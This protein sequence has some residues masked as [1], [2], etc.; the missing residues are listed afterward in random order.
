MKLGICDDETNGAINGCFKSEK[1]KDS[2][3]PAEGNFNGVDVQSW[4]LSIWEKAGT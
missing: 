1:L 4:R 2:V 3:S